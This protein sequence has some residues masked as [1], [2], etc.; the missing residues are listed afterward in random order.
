MYQNK[1]IG[2]MNI[3]WDFSITSAPS[4][5]PEGVLTD[6]VAQDRNEVADPCRD[7]IIDSSRGGQEGESRDEGRVSDCDRN[8]HGGDISMFST[9]TELLFSPFS[10]GYCKV[11]IC[12]G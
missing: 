1:L 6:P 7:E 11:R 3:F 9:L 8:H 2:T 5:S 4:A 10:D 12:E